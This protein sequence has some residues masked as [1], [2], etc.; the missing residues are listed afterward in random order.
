[1]RF[2]SPGYNG[3]NL[4]VPDMGSESSASRRAITPKQAWPIAHEKQKKLIEEIVM[5]EKWLLGERIHTDP[6]VKHPLLCQRMHEL[7]HACGVGAWLRHRVME[8]LAREYDIVENSV[9]P[10]PAPEARASMA[11]ASA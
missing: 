9:A 10:V 8:E 4:P 2:S 1:M 5:R 11:A 3:L 7:M 6:G